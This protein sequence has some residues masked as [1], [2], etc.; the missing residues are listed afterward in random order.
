MDLISLIPRVIP[1]LV[2][3]GMDELRTI[4]GGSDNPLVSFMI[5]A[6][7]TFPITK[8]SF[9]KAAEKVQDAV[10]KRAAANRI[11]SRRRPVKRC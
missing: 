5:E 3:N 10:A 9:G 1:V 11:Y 6:L 7:T 2:E 8:E 4:A